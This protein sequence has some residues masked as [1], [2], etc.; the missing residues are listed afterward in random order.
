[1]ELGN[2][3]LPTPEIGPDSEGA[4]EGGLGDDKGCVSS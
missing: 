2:L 4:G 1:M 3:G